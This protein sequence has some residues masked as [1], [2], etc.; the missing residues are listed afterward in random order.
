MNIGELAAFVCSHLDRY[1]IRVALSGGAVVSIYASNHYVSMDLDFIDLLQTTRRK[2][3]TVL[4]EIGFEE[5]RRYFVS[6]ETEFF[7]EFPSGPLAVGNEPVEKLAELQFETGKL[8]LLSP[9]DCVKDRLSAFY[10]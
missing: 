6:E 4:K 7:I 1:G 9:T 5:K 8:R 10:H 2:L 3:K